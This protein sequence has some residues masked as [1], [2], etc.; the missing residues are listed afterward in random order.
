MTEVVQQVRLIARSLLRDRGFTAIALVL[1]SIGIAANVTIFGVIDMVLL[2]PLPYAAPD[3]L[4]HVAETTPDGL[5]FSASEPNYID[6]RESQRTL[7]DL[8]AIRQANLDLMVNGEPARLRGQAV[9]ASFFSVLDVPAE[10]GRVFDANDPAAVAVLSHSLWQS[11]FG[12]SAD[13][14]GS[15]VDLSG[16]RHVV[17]GVM[18]ERFEFAESELWIPFVPDPAS[19]RDNHWLDV[20]GRLAPDVRID[21]AQGDL[22]RVAREIGTAHPQVASWSVKVTPLQ[23][24][25]VGGDTARGMWVLMVAVALLLL[26]SCA[27]VG[28]LFLAR[29][30]A[31]QGELAI[32]AALG[33]GRGALVR[34]M[35]LEA[36]L[37]A[38]AGAALGLLLSTWSFEALALLAGDRIPRLEAIDLNAR[39]VLFACALALVTSLLFGVLPA[40]RTSAVDVHSLLRAGGRTLTGTRTRLVRECLV[41]SQVALALVL[42]LGSGLLL[43][44]FLHIRGG[45]TGMDVQGLHAVPLELTS[46]RY[47]PDGSISI[48]YQDLTERIR[49]IPGVV[50]AGAATTHPFVA[51]RLVND[52]TPVERAADTPP[53]GF[54]QADWRVVTADYFAAAGVRL[55]QGRL[56]QSTDMYYNPRVAVVTR[57]FAERMWPDDDAVGSAFLWG[58]TTGDPITVVGVVEDVRDMDLTAP[59]PP[60]MFLSTG[61]MSMPMMTL[62]VRTEGTMRGLES[63]I[64]SAVWSL[65]PTVPVPTI[66]RVAESRSAAMAAPRLRAVLLAVFAICAL[67][68]AAI[69]VYAVVA[70]QVASRTREL[71]IR[72]ALGA[73]PGALLRL[74]LSRGALLVSIGI[75]VGLAAS[76]GLARLLQAVLYEVDA[77]DTLTFGAVPVVLAVVAFVAAWIPAW[78]TTRTDPVQALRAD[79]R[80]QAVGGTAT[81]R[82]VPETTPAKATAW[83]SMSSC[84]A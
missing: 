1:L 58:G 66:E 6:F 24:W 37:I 57:T 75:A 65:D 18:P 19:D 30:S 47:G 52:V 55:L 36:A 25:F 68:V 32:R 76:L 3:E 9:T 43:R 70:Y 49:A 4:V 74:V 79:W 64:R 54:M 5:L 77:H 2:Q 15:A 22:A 60:M 62:L 84:S 8:A 67:L 59:A 48:F 44:S 20:I 61:Q 51:W 38:A 28:N 29:G 23:E 71:G 13:V 42:L 26:L 41:V 78:R 31:R 40:L 81:L 33:A 46:S 63:A 50:A 7:V 69:G 80:L 12:G 14:V 27:N 21:V 10:L 82:P 56:F 45:A 34:H 16:T 35:W 83:T 17:V 11:Q 53:S 73:R 39:H 72:A